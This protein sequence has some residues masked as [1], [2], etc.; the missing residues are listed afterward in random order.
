MA[1]TIIKQEAW[2]TKLQER[3]EEPKYFMELGEVEYTDTKV[4]HNPYRNAS[5]AVAGT[6]GTAYTASDVTHTD[7]TIDI[8][9]YYN[10]VEFIDRADL[11][12]ST[13]VNQMNMA[14]SQGDALLDVVEIEFLKEHA[15]AGASIDDGDLATATNGGTGNPLEL[16]STNALE[17]LEIARLKIVQG[18][19]LMELNR[20]GASA[21][22]SP[23]QY[24]KFVSAAKSAGVLSFA[25]SAHVTGK[26]NKVNGF[27]L[28]ESNLTDSTTD[29][30]TDHAIAF[31]NKSIH[32][33]I[34][35]TT[36]GQIT[37]VENPNRTS[38]IDVASRI[39][40]QTKIWKQKA[41]LV[42]DLNIVG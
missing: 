32:I 25:E 26:V 15:N 36:F 18:K 5:T 38:G 2:K 11:A 31:V 21:V 24:S 14:A 1:N 42:V 33:G 17:V 35:R 7:D 37:V 40:F 16:S 3:L 6:R 30:G 20:K 34:L 12:Q 9:L 41:P 39:D 19:G 4:M 22:M 29:A 13:F 8:S 10:A 28:F 23:L 27:E